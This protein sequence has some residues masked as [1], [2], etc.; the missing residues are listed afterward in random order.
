MQLWGELFLVSIFA[1]FLASAFSSFNSLRSTVFYDPLLYDSGWMGRIHPPSLAFTQW[2]GKLLA[3]QFFRIIEKKF[4]EKLQIIWRSVRTVNDTIRCI[5]DIGIISRVRGEEKRE[6]FIGKG[7]KLKLKI[8]A[9]IWKGRWPTSQRIEDPFPPQKKT[10]AHCLT[11][12]FR[13]GYIPIPS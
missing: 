4:F 8:M 1:L 13:P 11:P 10:Y 12:A 9:A 3:L 7:I 2:K 5:Y 6:I